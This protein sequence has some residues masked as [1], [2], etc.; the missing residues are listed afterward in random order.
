MAT[1]IRNPIEWGF[2]QVQHVVTAVEVTGQAVRGHTA[3]DAAPAIRRIG[4]S[5]VRDALA[6]GAADFGAARSDVIFLCLLYPIAGLVLGRAVFGSGLFPML[7]PLVSGFALVAPFVAVGLYEMSRQRA[8]GH[9]ANWTTAFDVVRAPS[10]G[11]IVMLG[12]ALMAIFLLW[13]GTAQ[14]IYDATL[15]PRQPAS[16]ASF[17]R[18]VFTTPQGRTMIVLGIGVGFLFAVLVFAISAVSFPMLLDRDV[19]LGLAIGTSVRA[20][21]ANPLP[22]AVWGLVIAGGLVLGSL[23]LL[24]GLIIVLPILGHASWH[25]YRKVVVT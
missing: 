17:L 1:T 14:V 8:E 21:L 10:F 16:V 4:L 2:S 7:F 19:G 24:L 13:L 22:M 25:L 23:P 12:I 20:V 5:D 18:D 15:G 9:E 6:E 11:A 3:V